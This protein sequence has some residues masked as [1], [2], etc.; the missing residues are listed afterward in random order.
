MAA[1]I[2]RA[3]PLSTTDPA[4]QLSPPACLVVF[5]WDCE[6]WL[7]TFSDQG[8]VDNDLWRNVATLQHY[9]VAKGYTAAT[10]AA[11][12]AASPCYGPTDEVLYAQALSFISRA[13]VAKGYWQQQPIRSDLYG[14]VLT[15]TGHEQDVAT[16]IH[17]TQAQGGVPDYPDSGPFPVW[18]QPSTRAWFARALWAALSSHFTV[19]NL[20]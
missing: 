6:T 13:M 15:G 19:T 8:V 9:E 20:P 2:A 16:Y 7:N 1:L 5:T 4:L 18:N 3:M 17:Y 11:S 14:G 10:C 12:G